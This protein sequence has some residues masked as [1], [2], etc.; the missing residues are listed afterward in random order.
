MLRV[1]KDETISIT[2]VVTTETS[3]VY[4]VKRADSFSIQSVIDVN[5]PTAKE[6]TVLSQV[7]D[8]LTVTAHG[9]VTGLKGQASNSGGA[10]PTGISGSTDYFVVVVDAN[11]IKLSDTLAHALAGTDIINVSGDGTGTQTF[12]PTSIAGATVTLQKSNDNVNFD[13]VAAGTSIS[14]DGN[15]WFEID[16]PKYKY[17][18]LSYTLTAGMLS[19]TNYLVIKG[20]VS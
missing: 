8:T 2:N 19:S 20:A 17:I 3:D 15:V 4:D 12:T 9:F 14:A 1:T 16:K 10:L 18:R 6:F 11:T 13:A 7:D 5:T